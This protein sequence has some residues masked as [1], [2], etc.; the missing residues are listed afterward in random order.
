[1]KA[2]LSPKAWLEITDDKVVISWP[3]G[4]KVLA[5][6]DRAGICHWLALCCQDMRQESYGKG[7]R[8]GMRDGEL[9]FT[10][11]PEVTKAS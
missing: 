7:Y 8:Q 9:A 4:H 5:P 6:D 10:P 2:A 3:F 11:D 1:V